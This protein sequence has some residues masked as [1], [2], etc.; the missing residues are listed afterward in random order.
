MGL[1]IGRGDNCG[2]ADGLFGESSSVWIIA[3]IV[4]ILMILLLLL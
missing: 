4:I 1:G 2:Y 3:W